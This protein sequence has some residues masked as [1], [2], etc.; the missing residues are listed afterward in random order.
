MPDAEYNHATHIYLMSRVTM[1]TDALSP[2]TLSSN[3]SSSQ[4]LTWVS[5]EKHHTKQV[6]N[7]VKRF[8]LKCQNKTG[9]I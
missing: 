7:H 6:E 3:H 8:I 9:T 1:E 4:N 5:L 2:Y